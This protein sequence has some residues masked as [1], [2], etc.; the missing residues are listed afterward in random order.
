MEQVVNT[1][2]YKLTVDADRNRLYLW[3]RGPGENTSHYA[4]CIHEIQTMLRR[5]PAGFTALTDFSSFRQISPEWMETLFSVHK[6]LI[7]AGVS[8]EAEIHPP[9][10]ILRMQLD[11]IARQSGIHRQIFADRDRAE[12]WLD[13]A[14]RRSSS[15]L[16]VGMR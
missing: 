15:F 4:D 7:A 5:M 16:V 12:V 14:E 3:L 8:K 11:I 9:N 13:G 6:I 10:I 1:P 2:L